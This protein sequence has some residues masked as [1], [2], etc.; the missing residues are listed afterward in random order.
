MSNDTPTLKATNV[1]GCETLE[2]RRTKA[3]LS[4]HK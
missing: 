3:M 2:S 4:L 1:L